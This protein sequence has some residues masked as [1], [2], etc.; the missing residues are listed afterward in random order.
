VLTQAIPIEGPPAPP[1]P[2]PSFALLPPC[3][4]RTRVLRCRRPRQVAPRHIRPVIGAG[5]AERNASRPTSTRDAQRA[6]SREAA[7]CAR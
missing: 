2:L 4:R 3:R 6:A 5:D 7:H 1:P